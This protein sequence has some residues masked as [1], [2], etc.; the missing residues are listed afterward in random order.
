MRSARHQRV[1]VLDG[2]SEHLAIDGGWYA[3]CGRLLRHV[4]EGLEGLDLDHSACRLRL[5]H[6]LLPGEGIDASTGYCQ[7]EADGRF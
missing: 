6:R 7:V 1:L 5:E 2:T 4:L 3:A